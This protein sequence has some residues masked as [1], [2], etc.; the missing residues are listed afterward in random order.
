MKVM[1]LA[2]FA[3]LRKPVKVSVP[4]LAVEVEV[5]ALSLRELNELR[6]AC[7]TEPVPPQWRNPAR[8]SMAE[9]EANF[10]D[11]DYL[12]ARRVWSNRYMV[13]QVALAMNFVPESGKQFADAKSRA[14]WVHDVNEDLANTLT[15]EDVLVLIKGVH[16]AGGERAD[17][18]AEVDP[19]AYSLKP[20]TTA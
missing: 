16:Q 6:D 9:P 11:S 2:D 20:P 19:K 12:K 17:G 10:S 5:R 1:R 7:G 8:G 14:G 3:G 13:A 15:D 18:G 4:S